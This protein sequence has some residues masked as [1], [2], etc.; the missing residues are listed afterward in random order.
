MS[1]IAEKTY[2]CNPSAARGSST[3][4]SSSGDKIVYTNGRTVVIRDLKTP[5]FGITYSQHVQPATLARISPSGYYCASADA[6][7]NV[8]IWDIAGTDQ[9]LKNEKKAIS[10]KI[11]D[12]AWDADSQRIIAVGD[13]KEKFGVAFNA[14]S[15]NSVGEITGHS[16]VLNAVSIRHKR[17]FRA[18]TAGD[19]NT[20]VFYTGVPFKYQSSI[21]THTRFVQDV[22]FS[23]SGDVFASVGSDMK[24]FLYNGETGETLAELAGAHK[25]S[26]MAC[27]WSPDSANLLT[28]SMDRTVK[29]CKA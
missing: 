27:A 21:T 11:N 28:S 9:V 7:G 26:I 8:R 13:G 10:G 5:A 20:I 29:L 15:G 1:V 19:D 4:L 14:D 12:V 17:P 23:P 24:A 22:Q 18:V 16:K 6:G 2:P 25:G 3:K